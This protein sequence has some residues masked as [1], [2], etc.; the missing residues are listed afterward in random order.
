MKISIT[1]ARGFVGSHLVRSL[2]KLDHGVVALSCD[3]CDKPGLLKLL[4]DGN[5]DIIFHLASAIPKGE[6]VDEQAQ[7]TMYNTNVIGTENVLNCAWKLNTR[8]VYLSS[9]AVCSGGDWHHPVTEDKAAPGDYYSQT[10]L[11][12]EVLAEH[13]RKR[14]GLSVISVRLASVYGPGDRH[15]FVIPHFLDQVFSGENILIYG[16]GQRIMD[17]IYI[18]DVVDGIIKAG[19]SDSVGVFNIGSGKGTTIA[20]LGKTVVEVARE[21]GFN[22]KLI[23]LNLDNTTENTSFLVGDITKA[24]EFLNFTPKVSLTEGIKKCMEVNRFETTASM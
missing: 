14:F 1:G 2:K 6:N 3:V 23:H 8:M 21:Y 12:G 4:N 22:T 19:L 11:M 10:K 18:D 7:L 9:L 15:K 24:K 16:K 20:E 13:Y 17:F 5:Y